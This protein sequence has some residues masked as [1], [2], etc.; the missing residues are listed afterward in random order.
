VTRPQWRVLWYP[1]TGSLFPRQ[2]NDC[3]HG[4]GHFNPCAPPV[5]TGVATF[6]FIVIVIIVFIVIVVIIIV[7]MVSSVVASAGQARIDFIVSI[8]G[9]NA[10]EAADAVVDGN[11]T[12]PATAT[13]AE[14]ALLP[15]V[16][17]INSLCVLFDDNYD[18]VGPIA[19]D[20]S[21]ST[22]RD[23]ALKYDKDTLYQ[24]V[25]SHPIPGTVPAS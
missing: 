22:L 18:V 12:L 20:Q 4:L 13:P 17:F 11:S 3:I 1:G 25:T 5:P 21:V 7:I 19:K 16:Q 23:V 8:L 10:R 2:T 6:F 9:D 24:F 14:Q 15:R